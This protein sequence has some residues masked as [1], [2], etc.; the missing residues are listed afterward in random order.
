M[1]YKYAQESIRL[2]ALMQSHIPQR[3]REWQR[4]DHV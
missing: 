4:N 1:Q 3:L 2:F